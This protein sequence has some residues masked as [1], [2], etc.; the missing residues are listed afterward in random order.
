MGLLCLARNN[1]AEAATYFAKGGDSKANQEALGNMYIAQGQYERALSAL[2]GS[3]TNA[4]ALAMI[5]TKDYAG[6]K[7]VLGA[8]KNADANTAYLL[9]IVAAR[10]NDA[11]AVAQNLQKAVSLDPSLKSKIK[12]DIEFIKYQ[13]ALAGF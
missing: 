8:I 7:R 6:A 11:A 13:S 5:M 2:R 12:S 10:T 9:A 4:E 1:A 3:N